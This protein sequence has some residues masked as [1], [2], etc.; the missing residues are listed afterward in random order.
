MV[1]KAAG[2]LQKR[3][4]ITYVRGVLTILDN[5][6]LEAVSCDCYEEIKA[7]YDNFLD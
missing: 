2:T 7:E 6:G 3:G 1:N 5:K 4:L